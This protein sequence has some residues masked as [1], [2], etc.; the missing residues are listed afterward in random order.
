[1]TYTPPSQITVR[2][3]PYLNLRR[4]PAVRPG[5]VAGQLADG[6]VWPVVGIARDGFVAGSDVLWAQIQFTDPGSGQ[7]GRGFCRSD[8]FNPQP[9]PLPATQQ[10]QPA[11]GLN[12]RSTPVFDRSVNNKI[13]TMS[14]GAVVRVLGGAWENFDPASGKWWF[15]VEYQG[16]RGYAYARYLGD[17]STTQP[18]E[19]K[20]TGGDMT[21]GPD[22]GSASPVWRPGV[23]LAGVG[24]ADANVWHEPT[25][26][27]AIQVARLEAV[28]LVPLNDAN[29]MSRVYDWL[30]SQGIAF[31]M[32]RLT[33]KP[34]PVWAD[35]Q[36]AA[37]M[38]AAVDSFVE[39]ARGQLEFAYNNGVRYFEVHN[40]PNITPNPTDPI[41]D[42]LGS[43][44]LGPGDF[45][46]W[47][48]RVTDALRQIR[49]D[50]FLGFPGLA[51]RGS[52]FADFGG[53]IIKVQ[54]Q[55]LL[56]NTD[57]WLSICKS[58][59]D[60]KADWVGAHCYWQFDGTGQFGLE[61]ADSGGLYWKRYA[62]RFPGK[63]LFITEFSNNGGQIPPAEKGRQYGKYIAMLRNQK[64]VGAAF[65][66]AL[67]W[68][69]DPNREGWV[70]VNEQGK[71]RVGEIPGAMGAALQANALTAS[72]VTAN[73]PAVWA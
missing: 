3:Q 22:P 28:K 27:D 1:M 19:D 55:P 5:N 69:S 26:P 64:S 14:G 33:W 6:S 25:F 60:E 46:E 65:G 32:V 73:A 18:G 49:S 70:S 54:G 50:V 59:I 63:L 53:G 4:E 57:K 24:N 42:G 38:K 20:T 2:A 51:P 44:W 35:F 29:K 61:N 68:Q 45:A 36:P 30:R 56:W 31:V 13:V 58:T 66:F 47:F 23:C 12:L 9:A 37:R 7:K 40:E 39:T 41:G 72:R 21:T 62:A 43:A 16:R 71:F 11:D 15:I 34:N 52:D 67:Y 48:S 10:V 17:P 8:F